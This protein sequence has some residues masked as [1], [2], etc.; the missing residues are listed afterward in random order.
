MTAWA[1]TSLPAH[2]G[3]YGWD[4]DKEGQSVNVRVS[5]QTTFNNIS[6]MLQAALDGMGFAFVPLDIMQPHIEAG[7]LVPVLQD[8]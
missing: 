8:W 1:K 4:F 3:L 2:G 5:G 7:R 6:L